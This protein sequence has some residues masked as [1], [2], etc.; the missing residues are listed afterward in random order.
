MKSGVSSGGVVVRA[1]H[2]NNAWGGI[3]SIERLY[4]V[5]NLDGSSLAVGGTYLTRPEN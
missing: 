4:T 3:D 2:Y 5:H 1:S